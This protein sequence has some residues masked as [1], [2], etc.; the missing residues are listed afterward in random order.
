MATIP[1][2][3]LKD[4]QEF[5][6]ELPLRARPGKEKKDRVGGSIRVRVHYLK[7]QVSFSSSFSTLILCSLFL[8]LFSLHF[9]FDLNDVC[10]VCVSTCVDSGRSEKEQ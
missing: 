3:E 6:R 4:N 8:F 1:F 10:D 9:L 7:T 2:S 5:T